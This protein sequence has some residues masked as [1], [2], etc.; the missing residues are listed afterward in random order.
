MLKNIF[1]V[2]VIFTGCLPLA[3]QQNQQSAPAPNP[4]VLSKEQIEYEKK[5]AEIQE[6]NWQIAE[7]NDR[8]QKSLLEGQKAFAA[9]N[10]EL[11]IAEFDEAISLD[12]DYW[13]T[14]PVL[15]TNKAV[16]LRVSAIEKYNSA[17]IKNKTVTD[18]ARASF[19]EAIESLKNAA[20]IYAENPLP[21]GETEKISYEKGRYK[22]ALEM[23]E[24]Y[25]LLV[26][27]DKSKAFEAVEAFENYLKIETDAAKKEKAERELIRLKT[28]AGK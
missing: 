8:I 4:P 21:N 11:A 25:R 27:I 14:A 10:Y 12:P 19:Y 28:L 1:F 5:L 22:T 15:L 6:K 17:V 20:R 2:C 24:C 26:L 9:K 16:V 18:E 7:N 13:G 23:A 3:A